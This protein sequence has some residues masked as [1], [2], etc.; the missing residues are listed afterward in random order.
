MT[1]ISVGI[2]SCYLFGWMLMLIAG[3]AHSEWGIG[4]ISFRSAMGLSMATF[5]SIFALSLFMGLLLG[6]GKNPPSSAS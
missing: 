5:A 4:T 1:R 3:I 6:G 2:A